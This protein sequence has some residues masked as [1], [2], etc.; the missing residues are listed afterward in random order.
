[1]K[2]HAKPRGSLIRQMLKCMID[3]M[4]QK[5]MTHGLPPDAWTDVV[6]D[7]PWLLDRPDEAPE[8]ALRLQTMA[9]PVAMRLKDS[10]GDTR[11]Q[12]F[13]AAAVATAANAALHTTDPDKRLLLG[14]CIERFQTLLNWPVTRVHMRDRQDIAVSRLVSSRPTRSQPSRWKSEVNKNAKRRVHQ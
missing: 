13:C 10:T 4:E 3:N 12:I 1:M 7:L 11:R 8:K 6:L 5:L 2:Q 9:S 14:A